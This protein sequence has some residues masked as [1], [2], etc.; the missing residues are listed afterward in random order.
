M[1]PGARRRRNRRSVTL[2]SSWGKPRKVNATHS[3]YGTSEQWVYD[4]GYLYF[5]DGILTTVQN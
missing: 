1:S 2:A 4:G 5:R 3:A